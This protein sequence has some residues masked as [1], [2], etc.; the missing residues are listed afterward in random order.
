MTTTH[1]PP[2]YVDGLREA[3]GVLRSLEGTDPADPVELELERRIAN[4]TTTAAERGLEGTTRAARRWTLAEAAQVDDAIR[5]V[6]ARGEDFTTADVWAE[7]G[8]GFPVTKGIAAKMLAAQRAGVI[9]NTGRVTFNDH[10]RHD[11]AHG[12]RLALW[13]AT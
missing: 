4:A 8:A 11:H 5:T 6:A 7:L 10:P 13:K 9:V 2:T 3:L 12:Q 1:E